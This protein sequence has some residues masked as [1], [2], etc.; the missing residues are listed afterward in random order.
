MT[1]RVGKGWLRTQARATW[2]AVSPSS[3]PRARARSRRSRFPGESNASVAA[4]STARA[5]APN[6]VALGRPGR[7]LDEVGPGERRPGEERELARRCTRRARRDRRRRR[8]R[9]TAAGSP[10]RGRGWGWRPR[11]AGRRWRR[12]QALAS[13]S[14][15]SS[16][17]SR[18]P[19]RSGPAARCSASA[20]MISP[21]GTVSSSRWR[22]N[23]SI[24]SS[25]SRAEALGQV[26]PDRVRVDPRRAVLDGRMAAL[27]DRRTARRGRAG[28]PAIDRAP[29][30]SGTSARSRRR[31]RPSST[32]RSYRPAGPRPG[33]TGRG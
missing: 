31:C 12:A 14:R 9:P 32:N 4:T 2:L 28:R 11:T 8:S 24:R 29:A 3:R 7:A 19:P 23:R 13:S 18:R 21:T 27:G 15:P 5:S 10:G 33:P 25:P 22:R 30:R 6:A 26:L 17:S 16:S 1:A 20:V